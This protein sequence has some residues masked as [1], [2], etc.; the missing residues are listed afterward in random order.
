[1]QISPLQMVDA[2]SWKGLTTENHLGAIFNLQPQKASNI[3]AKIQQKYFGQDIE[4]FLSKYPT[5]YFETDDDYTWDLQSYGVDNIGLIEARVDGT[6]VTAASTAGLNFTF[7]DLVF[8]QDWFSAGEKI[9]GERNETYPILIKSARPE[10]T[11]WVYTCQL[12]TGDPTLF[13]PYE[14]I[15]AGKLFSREYAPV[16]RTLH[17]KGRKIVHRSNISMRNAFSQIRLQKETPGNMKDRKMGTAIVG[18]DGKQYLMWQQYESFMMDNEFRNDINRLLMFGT[19]NRKSDGSY[20]QKGDSGYSIVEGSGLREQCETSNTSFYTTFDIRDLAERLMDLSEGKLGADERSF[21]MA[22]GERGAY[23][24]HTALEDYVQL[25]QPLQNTDR[26]YKVTQNGIEMGLGYGGQFVEFKAFNGV[27]LN[28]SVMQMYDS[29]DRNK[30]LHP[31]G[32]VLESYR[33]DIWDMGTSDGVPNIQKVAVKGKDYIVHK[34]IAGLRNPFSPDNALSQ[35]GSAKDGWEE[36][37]FWC[38]GVMVT[39]PGRTAHFIC[40]AA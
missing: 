16:E 25:F 38:G 10:G 28:L 27:K 1:M 30:I 34:Y 24:F 20:E 19:A 33:Y 4:G 11:N 21:L 13:I 7:F 39:D 3:V 29:R 40:N 22:T 32:G 15:I 17:S 9:V 2:T 35:V 6:A 14:E 26:M 31:D 37:M 8:P 12:M 5:K 23:Q 18:K 36:H